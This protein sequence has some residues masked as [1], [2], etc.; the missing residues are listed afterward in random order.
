MRAQIDAREGPIVEGTLHLRYV[1]TFK[2]VNVGV[3]VSGGGWAFVIPSTVEVI[4]PASPEQ[5]RKDRRPLRHRDLDAAREAG[6][7]REVERLG[8]TWAELFAQLTEFTQPLVD[9]SWE[10]HG[11]EASTDDGIE[12]V[13]HY[14]RRDGV[15]LNIEWEPGFR[16][17]I[18]DMTA[19]AL[20]DDPPLEATAVLTRPTPAECRDTYQK[21]GWI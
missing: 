13:I 19:R 2:C 5:S 1:A 17:D 18:Y 14:L 21:H 16:L 20:M 11:T 3:E 10:L 7:V 9:A 12:T 6:L 8:G 15:E 4:A